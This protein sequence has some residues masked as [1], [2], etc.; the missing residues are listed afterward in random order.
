MEGGKETLSTGNV[1]SEAR[2]SSDGK[3][4]GGSGVASKP[5]SRTSSRASSPK[6]PAVVTT[7][8]KATPD[9]KSTTEAKIHS[10]TLKNGKGTPP[11]AS[12]GSASRIT[13]RNGLSGTTVHSTKARTAHVHANPDDFLVRRAP[14]AHLRSARSASCERESSPTAEAHQQNG[15]HVSTPG[16]VTTKIGDKVSPGCGKTNQGTVT[17]VHQ[18]ND[19]HITTPRKEASDNREQIKVSIPEKEV[20]SNG[21]QISVAENAVQKNDERVLPSENGVHNNGDHASPVGNGVRSNGVQFSAGEII[22]PPNLRPVCISVPDSEKGLNSPASSSG[23]RKSA[24]GNQ[25]CQRDHTFMERFETKEQPWK[26]GKKVIDHSHD[27]PTNEFQWKSSRKSIPGVDR[28]QKSPE[29]N[30]NDIPVSR[31]GPGS[32]EVGVAQVQR[33]YD[34]FGNPVNVPENE[35]HPGKGRGNGPLAGEW[36]PPF[37]GQPTK[38]ENEPTPSNKAKSS[39]RRYSDE[40]VPPFLGVDRPFLVVDRPAT[41]HRSKGAGAG[42]PS[43]QWAPP[44]GHGI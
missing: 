14:L 44:W 30:S 16:K 38:A 18:G 10:P 9:R 41:W 24:S 35:W 33:E 34:P 7:P 11:N 8:K 1:P 25:D 31:K 17:A 6:A 29:W 39:G 2:S 42:P 23:G 21:N 26:P 4:K 15:E 32:R 36:I 27:L 28:L 20:R 13:T 43:N 37:R 5:S 40:Y 12:N 19:E 3:P 22:S